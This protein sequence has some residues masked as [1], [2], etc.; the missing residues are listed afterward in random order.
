MLLYHI[1]L[2]TKSLIN[3]PYMATLQIPQGYDPIRRMNYMRKRR[4]HEDNIVSLLHGKCPIFPAQLAD[5]KAIKS[6]HSRD[7]TAFLNC[8]K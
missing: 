6:E 8:E 1:L 2:T 7:P 4:I 5:F 3:I